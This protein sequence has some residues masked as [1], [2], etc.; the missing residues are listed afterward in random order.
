MK[1]ELQVRTDVRKSPQYEA[2]DRRKGK[3]VYLR[4]EIQISGKTADGS[5]FGVRTYTQDIS[6]KGCCFRF[7]R[8]L[9]TGNIITLEVVGRNSPSSVGFL[10]PIPLRVV[11]AKPEEEGTAWL[12]GAEFASPGNPW[13]VSFPP[14]SMVRNPG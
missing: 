1:T 9:S 8:E 5:E 3:R 12:V 14:K 11:W 4:Y 10:S 2:D 6:E 13:A 7:P